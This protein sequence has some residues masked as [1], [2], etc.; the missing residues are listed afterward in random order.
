MYDLRGNN[1]GQAWWHRSFMPI[2][3]RQKDGS[4]PGF[5]VDLN[6]VSSACIHFQCG[7]SNWRGGIDKTPTSPWTLGFVGWSFVTCWVPPNSSLS[8]FS[9]WISIG[10]VTKLPT[11][12]TPDFN[13]PC[14]LWAL[15][16]CQA[17]NCWYT[18]EK[19]LWVTL[20]TS[21]VQC[22]WRCSQV[23]HELPEHIPRVQ[24]CTHTFI[25][26]PRQ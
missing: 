3:Q 24:I 5:Y 8:L 9:T 11:A 14:L 2:L 20:C 16:F 18:E 10:E 7:S 4:L 6:L 22:S 1:I 21:K 25:Y 15:A 17:M 12:W 23:V 13:S 26:K 19:N